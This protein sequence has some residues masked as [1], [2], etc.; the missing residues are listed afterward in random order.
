MRVV[1][2]DLTFTRANWGNAARCWIPHSRLHAIASVII[3]TGDNDNASLLC[4]IR[5]I[6]IWIAATT[7]SANWPL[8][9][10]IPPPAR[11]PSPKIH[12]IPPAVATASTSRRWVAA[13][14]IVPNASSAPPTAAT[15]T[16]I[17]IPIVGQPEVDISSWQ[18][19]TRNQGSRRRL[20]LVPR[21]SR[22]SRQE[23]QG[24]QNT[25]LEKYSC[26]AFYSVMVIFL[27]S[28]TLPPRRSAT[29]YVPLDEK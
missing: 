1:L 22:S 7:A 26:H 25:E 29:K 13:L 2:V 23:K 24:H 4:P 16:P 10:W 11:S 14:S 3:T 27:M 8:G 20:S 21:E 28:S 9:I 17:G 18:A 19:S 6:P 5:I 15:P 12:V